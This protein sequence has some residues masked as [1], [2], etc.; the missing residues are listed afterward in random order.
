MHGFSC[1]LE[2]KDIA[3]FVRVGEAILKPAQFGPA[4]FIARTFVVAL[5]IVF[6]KR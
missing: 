3:P 4:L 1:L 5:T 6:T 2:T